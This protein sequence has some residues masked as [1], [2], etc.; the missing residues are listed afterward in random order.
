MAGR[1]DVLSAEPGEVRG[2]YGD[3]HIISIHIISIA[4]IRFIGGELDGLTPR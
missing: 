3:D 2:K 4:N 1:A